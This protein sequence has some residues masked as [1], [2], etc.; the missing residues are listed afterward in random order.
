[1]ANYIVPLRKA[2]KA[3]AGIVRKQNEIIRALRPLQNI[4]GI[5]PISV[6]TSTSNVLVTYEP[7]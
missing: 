4:Q 5:A 3:F 1:M 6:K 7:K 2:P